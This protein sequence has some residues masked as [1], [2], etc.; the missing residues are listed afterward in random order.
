MRIYCLNC[1]DNVVL[2]DVRTGGHPPVVLNKPMEVKV[3]GVEQR[4]P[5]GRQHYPH[6]DI[7]QC[8]GCGFKIAL[9]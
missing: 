4:L 5:D 7:R 3:I 1:G 9:E 2:E 6:V 8:K